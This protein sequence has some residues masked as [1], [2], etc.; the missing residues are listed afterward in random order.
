MDVPFRGDYFRNP[1][2]RSTACCYGPDNAP[3]GRRSPKRRCERRWRQPTFQVS[4]AS[5]ECRQ[6]FPENGYPN[7]EQTDGNQEV[8][9]SDGINGEEQQIQKAV[10]PGEYQNGPQNKG[11][12]LPDQDAP[13]KP[14]RELL[15]QT[16]PSC[17]AG[18]PAV[19][20]PKAERGDG[21]WVGRCLRAPGAPSVHDRPPVAK[22]T[23]T[24]LRERE[25]NGPIHRRMICSSFLGVPQ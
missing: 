22:F 10:D 1:S 11:N 18:M 13:P 8:Q 24:Y 5:N 7:G 15:H 3:S 14:L 17:I 12:Y 20:G 16:C 4:I 19:W 25:K 2:L 23:V 21:S 6:I 9:S